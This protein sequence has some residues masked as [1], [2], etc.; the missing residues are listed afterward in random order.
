MTILGVDTGGTFTDFVL[1]SEGRIRT[2][3]VLSTPAA[4]EQAIL[5]GI[6]EL[7]LTP[8]GLN[9]IHGSTVA[10]NAALEGQGARTLYVTN[11]GLADLLSIGR[12]ARPD[13]YDLQP[14][15][16]HPPVPRAL[17][18]ETGGR[19]GADGSEVEPLRAD[20]C[21]ALQRAVAQLAP[22]S[23]AINLLFSY[24]DDRA[25]RALENALPEGLFVARSSEVLPL[26]GEY[27]RGIAT[28]LNARL[29]PLV[30]RYIE[31]LV[32]GLTGSRVSVMQSSGEAVSAAQAARH[33]ARLLLSGPAGGLAGA[34]FAASASDVPRLLTF[35]MGGTSTDVAVIE[36]E[37]RLTTSGRIADLPVALPMVDM[38]TIGSGGGSIARLDAGGMLRVGPASA[39]ATPGPACYGRGGRHPTV[40][41]ANV[42]LGRLDAAGFLD[43]RMPLDVRA[44]QA[45][46]ADLA[47]A[48]GLTIEDAAL[49]VIHLADEQMA[50]ALRAISVRR[51]L[52]PRDFTLASFGGAGGLHVCALAEALG[53]TQAMVPVHAGV[54]CALGMVVTPPGRTLTRTRLGP[55]NE[56]DAPGISAALDELEQTAVAELQAEGLHPSHLRVEKTLDLRYRGQ[57]QT[58]NLPWIRVS[59][60]CEH[61]HQQ[62]QRIYG[63][64][65]DLPVELVN[66]RVR[67]RGPVT[68]LDLPQPRGGET[69]TNRAQ[70]A[71]G[72]ATP[73]PIRT[74]RSLVG[75]SPL[76]GPAIVADAYNTVW[77][78]PG[79][80]ATVDQRGNLNL[81]SHSR[82]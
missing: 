28:W 61:F 72:C 40:T 77:I 4:P 2:H 36:G 74:S 48:M 43:G 64:R 45:A 25:E 21:A 55:L 6:A 13:L 24:L 10:T 82:R 37:P 16:R 56:A 11:R 35:D 41:D 44:A 59:D 3:K 62:H 38:H 20:D 9:L 30:A 42:I 26:A 5:Q 23:V 49:G 69:N 50:R 66:L 39:G 68:P 53:M 14:P 70:V 79:W 22:E 65:L 52:D 34:A 58:L 81:A 67:V 31:R 18:F 8:A 29:G 33:T 63:H 54:L 57:A 19:V 7:G 71:V 12:Q 78:A 75:A 80:H 73:I 60:T 76:S 27:E 1:W 46:F 51:G 32:G 17:C 47:E 15:P